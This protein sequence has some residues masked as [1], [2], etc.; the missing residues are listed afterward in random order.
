MKTTLRAI[1]LIVLAFCFGVFGQEQPKKADQ[2]DDTIRITTE[3]VQTGVTVVDKQG[4]FVDD[5][6]PDQ[7]ELRVD[8]KPMPISFFERVVT[9]SIQ[10]SKAQLVASSG[11]K[12]SAEITSSATPH[13]RT[14]VFFVDDFHLAAASVDHVRKAILQFVENEMA[15]NDQVLVASATGQ[16]G[17]LAQL[18]DNKAVLRAAVARLS[19]RQYTARDN[20]S[21]PMTEY[22]AIR[23][24]KGDRDAIGY[25]VS[26][27]QAATV[28]RS[29]GGQLGPPSGGM[30]VVGQRSQQGN[31]GT[32][33]PGNYRW[34][35]QVRRRA[36]NIIAQSIEITSNTLRSLE[37]VIR[38]SSQLGGRKL[39]FFISDGFFLID[40]KSGTTSKLQQITDAAARAGV[41]IYSL[42]ARGMTNFTDASSNRSDPIG[43]LSRSNVGELSQSQD[44]LSALASDTGG[45]A[46]FNSDAFNSAVSGALK[47][48][49]NYY[50]LAWRP[51]NEEQQGGKFKRLEVSVIGRPELTVRLPSGYLDAEALA[52]QERVDAKTKKEE[53][54]GKPEAGKS[55]TEI[56]L[57]VALGAGVP[58]MGLETLL[59]TSF[60]DTPN[61]GMILMASTQVGTVGLGYGDDGNQPAGVDMACAI[62]NDQGKPV[63]GFKTRLNVKPLPATSMQSNNEGV[64]YY[65]RAP[66]SPGLYQV[67]VAARDE[68]TGKIGS[69]MQWIEIPD[70]KSNRLTLS[71]LLLGGHEAGANENGGGADGGQQMQFSVDRR[72]KRTSRMSILSFIYNATR[73]SSGVPDLLGQIQVFRDSKAVLNSPLRKVATDG[74]D[75]QARIPFGGDLSLSTLPAGY[76]TLQ[77]TITD[78]AA[79]TTSSQRLAFEVQ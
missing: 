7:F 70:L 65:Y 79:K 76:Y 71:S 33:D 64:I 11:S 20:E 26:Q 13:G 59:S 78:N 68:K 62:L 47:E 19:Y 44:A 69:A 8:G 15:V 56:D 30:G 75:D 9:G 58:R 42:D 3:L 23:I 32:A 77:I 41:V 12:T 53:T 51:A 21:V 34:E 28:Y 31:T 25:Y 63:N 55:P 10:E 6:K 2:T 60:I 38:A 39:V 16:I 27:L 57:R 1:T 17:F 49:S 74:L 37:S 72:F 18:T 24:S 35:A 66:L 36:E 5:L 61:N 54:Q 48:T 14:I 29:P 73:S 4:R 52:E 40:N 43:Q 67:R 22:Q 46:L 50:L 45:R